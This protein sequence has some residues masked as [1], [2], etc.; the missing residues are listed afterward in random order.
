M[1]DEPR[2]LRS[3]IYRFMNL[4]VTYKNISSPCVIPISSRN[5]HKYMKNKAKLIT[6]YIRASF[7]NMK[8]DT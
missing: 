6:L 2:E 4:N 3:L 5:L 7:A 8:L 1:Q